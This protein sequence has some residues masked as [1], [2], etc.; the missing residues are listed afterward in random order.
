MVSFVS[1]ASHCSSM[2]IVQALSYFRLLFHYVGAQL[3]TFGIPPPLPSYCALITPIHGMHPPHRRTIRAFLP[4]HEQTI[5]CLAS[6]RDTLIYC[7]T[8]SDIHYILASRDNLLEHR[9]SCNVVYISFYY[10][11]RCKRNV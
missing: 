3:I 4:K 5:Q 10:Y 8:Q 9:T 2:V 7:D 6:F 11:R 1:F